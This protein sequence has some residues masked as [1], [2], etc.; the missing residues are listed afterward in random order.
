MPQVD[1]ARGK[2][3]DQVTTGADGRAEIEVPPGIATT[4]YVNPV[5]RGANASA[6]RDLEAFTAGEQRELVIELGTQE[7]AH[8]FARVTSHETHAPIAGAD[9]GAVRPRS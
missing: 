7:D 3:D 4:L 8:F 5:Q 6:H 2:L 1:G 9:I